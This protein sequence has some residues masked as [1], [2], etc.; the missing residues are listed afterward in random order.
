VTAACGVQPPH[1][2]PSGSFVTVTKLRADG[3]GKA[4]LERC[5]WCGRRFEVLDRPGRPKRF[6]RRSCRQRQ[7]EARQRSAALGLGEDE[8]VLARSELATLQDDLWILQCAADDAR[9][10]LDDA[11]SV[12][13]LRRVIEAL[14]EAIDPVVRRRP[15]D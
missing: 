11:T 8:L 5:A 9:V 13:E 15:G 3:E 4:R 10:D 14:L 1:C 7:Y 6:C 2:S 12:K